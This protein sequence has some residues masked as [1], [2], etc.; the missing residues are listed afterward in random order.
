MR[1][2]RHLARW[3]SIGP[4][5]KHKRSPRHVSETFDAGAPRRRE[6]GCSACPQDQV[7]VGRGGCNRR[8]LQT[9]LCSH[10]HHITAVEACVRVITVKLRAK[11]LYCCELA[12]PKC[13]KIQE[14]Q[15]PRERETLRTDK[16][17][18][19]TAVRVEVAKKTVKLFAATS[20]LRSIEFKCSRNGKG[21]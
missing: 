1:L 12:R 3:L 20:Y 15:R 6:A 14:K 16:S 8:C 13:P 11:R 19:D 7:S 4:L 17:V 9:I 2:T 18:V 21:A 5:A 10:P